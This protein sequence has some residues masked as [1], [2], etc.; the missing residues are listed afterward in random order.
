MKKYVTESTVISKMSSNY[1]K[2]DIRDFVNNYMHRIGNHTNITAHTSL[3]AVL[4]SQ[5]PEVV[6]YIDVFYIESL[7]YSQVIP[8]LVVEDTLTSH[9][10]FKSTGIQIAKCWKAGCMKSSKPR[11]FGRNFVQASRAL[12]FS[13]ATDAFRGAHYSPFI[14]NSILRA[15]KPYVQHLCEE[16]I[17]A[18]RSLISIMCFNDEQWLSV[19]RDVQSAFK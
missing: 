18:V 19:L 2:T 15:R 9:C 1:D 16:A 11:I 7:I 13:D 14:F 3:A 8:L 12:Y 10:T 17:R 6:L 5:S 4:Y